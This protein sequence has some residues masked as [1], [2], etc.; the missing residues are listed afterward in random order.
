[1]REAKIDIFSP[2]ILENVNT[3]C[4]TS[5]GIIRRD[6]SLVMGAGTAKLFRDRFP[7]ID[8]KAGSLVKKN[9]NV[10]QII[11]QPIITIGKKNIRV[12]INVVA[13][14]T[15]NHWKDASD[16]DLIM[17]SARRLMEMVKENN[18]QYVALPQPGTGNGNLDWSVMRE[19]LETVLD[20]RIIIVY[21]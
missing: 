19:K 12:P 8:R 2:T 15:K 14:P 18:W 17:R 4:F 9:G 5:N 21:V 6:G 7:G 13:F 11:D 3:I 10:C 1:M 20:N 16:T